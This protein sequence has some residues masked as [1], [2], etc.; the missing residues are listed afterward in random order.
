MLVAIILY[1]ERNGI[2]SR[3]LVRQAKAMYRHVEEGFTM[4]WALRAVERGFAAQDMSLYQFSIVHF[5][6]LPR[7]WGW[8]DLGWRC[9]TRWG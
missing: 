1:L 8:E 5:T 7:L 9:S 4:D 3:E 2:N 6:V